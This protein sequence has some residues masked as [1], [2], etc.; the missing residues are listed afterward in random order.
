[1]SIPVRRP[2]AP[3][4]GYDALVRS[5]RTNPVSTAPIAA[6]GAVL[7][8]LAVAAWA[9]AALFRTAGQGDVLTFLRTDHELRDAFAWGA[10]Q[11][12][13]ACAAGLVFGLASAYCWARL[14]YPGRTVLRGLA[15]APLAVPLVALAVGIEALFAPGTPAAD[16]VLFLG[17]EPAWL[18]SGTG[19][20]VLAHSLNS[21]A[22]VGWFAS[23]AW[24]SVDA[25][26]VDAART[27][28]A[29][30]LRAARVAAWPVVWPAAVAASG[31]TFL[32]SMLSYGVVAILA[33]GRET[34]EGLTVRLIL[35][36]DERAASM[37]AVTTACVL[38]C[39]LVT[40]Q[41]LRIPS[42]NPEWTRPPQR[43]QGPGRIIAAVAAVP[44]LLVVG[45]VAALLVRAASSSDG[46]STAHLQS[47]VEGPGASDVRQAALGSAL[48]ALPA[49]ALT[50]V[51]GV[52]A[53]AALGRMRGRGGAIRTTALLIPIALSPAALA[54]GWWLTGPDLAPRV[55]LALVQAAVAFP[56]VAGTVARMRP[57]P[58]PGTLVAARTLGARRLR[59]WQ[60]LRG[61]SYV[62]AT[63]AGFFV[64]VGLVFG[65]T[66]AAAVARVPG[67]T[68]PLRLLELERQE[69]TGQAAA[70][71]AA[72]LLIGV[73]AFT[74]GDPIIARLGRARR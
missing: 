34:P 13:A 62:I 12:I 67:G 63:A 30:R 10:A 73:V 60:V 17:L 39:G 65:E 57:S 71:A 22:I 9:L 16:L 3:A 31:I 68:L 8:M 41:F 58:R 23:V 32:Q 47:L 14:H 4:A 64:T 46:F 50:A 2:A 11:A 44:A 66:S 33:R 43:A 54:Y 38:V 74:L 49:A 6:A 35:A 61:P 51:W 56:F 72:I 40:I 36:G 18:R 26:K 1:M 52:M 42:Q 53:G 7:T 55:I 19:A 15:V 5:A 37:A 24:A 27:L 21:T 48:A 29:G 59:A 20:V 70:L 28:G 45:A 25:R 69:A